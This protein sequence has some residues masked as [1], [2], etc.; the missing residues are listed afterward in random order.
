MKQVSSKKERAKKTCCKKCNKRTVRIHILESFT[1]RFRMAV[2]L[3]VWG[4]VEFDEYNFLD[5]LIKELVKNEE[6]DKEAV[7]A[8]KR[9]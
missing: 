3:L 8:W 7:K 4:V 5:S 1:L 6:F 2:K 9:H